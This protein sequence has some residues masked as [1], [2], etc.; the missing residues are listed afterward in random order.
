MVDVEWYDDKDSKLYSS[1]ASINSNTGCEKCAIMGNRLHK[2]REELKTARL[3]IALLLEDVESPVEPDLGALQGNINELQISS[4]NNNGIQLQD[5]PDKKKITKLK[6]QNENHLEIKNRFEALTNLINS[7]GQSGLNKAMH[8]NVSKSTTAVSILEGNF[9][10]SAQMN[11]SIP[12]IVNGSIILKSNKVPLY[13]STTPE[14]AVNH[15]F[16]AIDWLVD[17]KCEDIFFKKD[18]NLIGC[19]NNTIQITHIG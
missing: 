7:N 14:T 15:D 16:Q 8:K 5:S 19:N 1:Q 17:R 9:E 10:E 6:D 13:T 12:V 2:A 4:K 3:I 18:T 11:Y